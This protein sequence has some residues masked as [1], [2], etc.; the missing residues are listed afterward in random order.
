[1][2]AKTALFALALAASAPA[3]ALAQAP[4]QQP[5]TTAKA[6][7]PMD[8]TG[9]WV[10]IVTEDWRWRMIT[11][12][13]GDFASLPLNPAG[14]AAAGAWNLDADNA[15]G[16]AAQCK[17]YGVG[18]IVRIPGRMRI[19]WADDA[20]L[21]V[22]Y[23]AGQ[24]SRLFKFINQRPGALLPA[25][26][27]RAPPQ[28][29]ATL[30]G[31]TRAQWFRQPQIRGLGAPPPQAPGGS[32]R[33]YT[34]N[35]T[36]GYLRKNGVPYSADAT[37]TEH[38]NI[39]KGPDKADWLVITTIIDDPRYLQVPFITSTNFKRETDTSK[40]NP[41]PCRTPAPL[42]APVPPPRQ[43]GAAPAAPAPAPA[44]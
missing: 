18:G 11:P 26:S 24:Q 23:D 44:R 22:D 27:Q 19:S 43:P 29:P 3:G 21:K 33:A 2:K 36:D 31:E 37:I 39:L 12:P 9:Q 6:A 16:P 25:L 15:A 34:V 17:A 28:G 7:A 8:L 4:P 41:Q 38:W 5:Q 40:W 20:T 35:H 14:R 42:E 32:L 13:K 30:Q 10:A 1:M